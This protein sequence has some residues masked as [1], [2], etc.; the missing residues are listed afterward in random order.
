[1]DIIFLGNYR[2]K[3][4]GLCG[5]VYSWGGCCP[6]LRARDYKEPVM[7]LEVKDGQKQT[8]RS[9]TDVRK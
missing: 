4:Q 2:G 9:D 8:D 5:S 1:M 7:I 6:E 3:N